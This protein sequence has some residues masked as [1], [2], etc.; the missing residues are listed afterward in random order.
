[1]ELL[2]TN[3]AVGVL[4][5]NIDKNRQEMENT[6]AKAINSQ[7][8]PIVQK[9][10]KAKDLEKLQT[11]LDILSANLQTLSSDLTGGMNLMTTLTPTEVR[12]ATMI[13][14]G[15]TTQEI[16][17]K[18]YISLHTAKTHRRNIRKKLNVRN[19][20]INLSSYLQSIM[21]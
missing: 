6:I 1:M 11:E 9:L 2:D 17:D 21:W 4:A 7:I 18:L 10:R 12:V 8:M 15:L 5:R 13:K 20:R 19:S 3:R 14:N 16:S